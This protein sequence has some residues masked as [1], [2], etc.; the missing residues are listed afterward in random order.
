MTEREPRREPVS[1]G[2]GASRSSAAVVA[3]LLEFLPDV[4]RMLVSVVRDPAVP[5]PAKYRAGVFLALG[6]SPVDAVPL[7]GQATVVAMVALA[8][9]QLVD[10]AGEERL[11]RHWTGTDAGFRVVMLVADT[12]LRPRRMFGRAFK[13]AYGKAK[14]G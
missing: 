1:P 8:I 5:A 2:A 12:G 9:K 13:A 11:R 14:G 3:D 7:L 4:V 6:V 10:G